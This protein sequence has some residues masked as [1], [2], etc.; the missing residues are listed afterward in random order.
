MR[1]DRYLIH[2][3]TIE[4]ESKT[5]S[6]SGADVFTWIDHNTYPCR[7]FTFDQSVADPALGDVTQYDAKI[8]LSPNNDIFLTDR[9]KSVI[10]EDGVAIAGKW[11]IDRVVNKRR[12]RNQ[13]TV[14]LLRKVKEGNEL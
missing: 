5:K 6:D 10:L 8:I 3:C 7:F 12:L 9:V 14:L 1:L 11:L 13:A 2:H 4:R